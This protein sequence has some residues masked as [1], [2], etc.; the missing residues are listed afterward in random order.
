MEVSLT[1]P[2]SAVSHPVKLQINLMPA[3][4]IEISFTGLP[5]FFFPLKTLGKEPGNQTVLQLEI[6]QSLG[7]STNRN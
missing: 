6:P 1:I 5:V 3:H 7:L 2:K 4:D